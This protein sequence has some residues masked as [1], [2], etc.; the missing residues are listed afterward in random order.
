VGEGSHDVQEHERRHEHKVGLPN[1]PGAIKVARDAVAAVLREAAWPEHMIDVA[2][3]V[4]SELVTNAVIHARTP[5]RVS[6]RVDGSAWIRV[7]DSAGSALPALAEPGRAR[8]G[9]MGLYLVE[10]MA[11]AWGVDRHGSGKVVWARID[12]DDDPLAD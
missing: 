11:G 4:T 12:L 3:V 5:F 2:R 9:G 1:D 6:V 10:A 8:P 7:A